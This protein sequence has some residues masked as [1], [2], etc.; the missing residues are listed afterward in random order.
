MYK[1]FTSLLYYIIWI[2][3][4]FLNQDIFFLIPFTKINLTIFIRVYSEGAFNLMKKIFQIM[5]S[6]LSTIFI[7]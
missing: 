5:L 7:P 2:I 1:L 3:Y 4:Y 6:I